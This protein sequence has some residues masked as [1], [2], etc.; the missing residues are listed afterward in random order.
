LETNKERETPSLQ[1]QGARE[2]APLQNNNEEGAI[3]AV[4]IVDEDGEPPHESPQQDGR[5][6]QGQKISY[7]HRFDRQQLTRL[8]DSIP[9]GPVKNTAADVHNHA[10]AVQFFYADKTVAAI[11]QECK[12]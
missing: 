6:M 12:G 3:L 11:V 8:A 2:T 4:E 9:K 7:D 5:G 10:L 1:D